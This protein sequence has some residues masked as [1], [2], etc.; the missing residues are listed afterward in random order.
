MTRKVIRAV[1]LEPPGPISNEDFEL[2]CR[3]F[4]IPKEQRDGVRDF[5]A[6]AVAGFREVMGRER[7]LPS[8]KEDRLAL[9]RAIDRLRQAENLLKQIKGPAGR[10]ALRLA[11]RQIA[12]AVSNAWLQRR[13]PNDLE[14][15]SETRPPADY[16]PLRPSLRDADWLREA[17][18]RLLDYRVDFMERRGGTAIAKLIA[19]EI[20]VLEEGRRLIVHLPDG[21]R[22]LTHRRYML[23]ALAHLWRRLGRRPTSGASSFGAFCEVVFRAIGWPTKGVNSALPSAITLSRRLYR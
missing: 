7:T 4:Q 16:S 20:T 18:N 1:D 14:A 9:T 21:R 23:A 17:E 6:D 19:D 11:G 12:P 10:R 5:L 8:R 15:P 22:P 2:I 13:F 3:V